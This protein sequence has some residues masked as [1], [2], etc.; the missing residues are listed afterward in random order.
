MP[1]RCLCQV[2]KRTHKE[3]RVFTIR[4]DKIAKRCYTNDTERANNK[5]KLRTKDSKGLA[6]DGRGG[7]LKG[8][9]LVGAN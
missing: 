4:V 3:P 1:K 5:N 6:R 2:A 8:L 7:C 9:G